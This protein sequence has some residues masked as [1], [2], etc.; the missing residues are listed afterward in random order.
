M[1]RDPYTHILIFSLVPVLLPCAVIGSY[2]VF[3]FFHVFRFQVQHKLHGILVNLFEF[4]ELAFF[5]DVPV[6]GGKI[7]F[8]FNLNRYIAGVANLYRKIANLIPANNIFVIVKFVVF[9]LKTPSISALQPHFAPA[10]NSAR[11]LRRPVYI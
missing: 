4:V 3:K 2:G 6:C 9:G 8:D 11:P 1:N 7:A 5:V 10:L